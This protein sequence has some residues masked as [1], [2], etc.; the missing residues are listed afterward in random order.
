MSLGSTDYVDVVIRSMENTTF[1]LESST[2][3]LG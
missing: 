1:R 3:E 2:Y